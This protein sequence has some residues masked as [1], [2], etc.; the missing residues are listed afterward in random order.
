M[1]DRS[2][3]VVPTGGEVR[4]IADIK[5]GKR[6]RHDLGDINALAQKIAD[7]G[8]FHPIVVNRNNE[9]MVGHRRLEAA[10]ALGWDKVPVTVNDQA[11]VV[12]AE[13]AENAFRKD[14]LPSEIDAI[15][16]TIEPLEQ[17]AA[18][19][20]QV[21]GLNRGQQRA[22]VVENFHNGKTR[23]KVAA[24]V[25]VSGRTLD[26]IKD[27][28]EAAEAEPERFGS[29]V[30]HMDRTGK[31]HQAYAELRRIQIEESEALPAEGVEAEVIVGD[32]RIEGHAVA[33]SSVD[34]IFTEPPYA[35]KFVPL[36]G[37]LT[38]F[39]ARTLIDGGSLVTYF[40]TRA[41]PDVLALMT[42]HLRYHWLP[43][44]TLTGGKRTIPGKA[45]GVQVGYKPLLWFTKGERR[46]STIV[47]DLIKSE[48]G[49]KVSGHEWAQGTHEALYYIGKLS[50]KGSLIVDPFLGSG[51]T[52][53]AALKAGRRF[54]GFEI[55]PETARKAEARIE[56]VSGGAQ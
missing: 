51:T 48:R 37:D 2:Q 20:R 18:R 16:R 8:L 56:R 52:A 33:D 41:L 47:A 36:F 10:K 23:D 49:N 9:L 4:A 40:G 44:V 11:G 6:H 46:T 3:Q 50:R 43:A 31:V 26:K 13:L 14:Y 24:F 34:L 55:N 19:E 15:R 22:P 54:V 39:A 28:C 29:L 42:P 21:G 17:A 45:V 25:G 32:F 30:A 27:V 1:L 35:R 5:V 53:V 7:F 38:Q 12:D